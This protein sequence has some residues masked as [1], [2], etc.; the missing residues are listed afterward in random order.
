MQLDR[1]GRGQSERDQI[2][3]HSWRQL[4]PQLKLHLRSVFVHMCVH[5]CVFQVCVCGHVNKM[6]HAKG[7]L[8]Y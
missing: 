4:L 1:S 8:E 2:E 3:C 5:V 6:G 7:S